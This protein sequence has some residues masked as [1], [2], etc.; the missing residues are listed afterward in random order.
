MRHFVGI[1]G[2]ALVACNGAPKDLGPPPTLTVTSPV[3]SLVQGQAGNINVT[4][5]ATPGDPS[6]TI[7]SVLVNG[8]SATV[9]TDGS[10][11]ATVQV[12][13]GATLIHTIATDSAGGTANDT[14]SVEAGQIMPPGANID[15]A[16]TASVSANAFANISA[17]ATTII[18]QTDFS[19]LIAPLQPMQEAGSSPGTGCLYDQLFVQDVKFTG[20]NL[21]LVPVQGGIQFS[22]ELDGLDVPGNVMF[23]VACISGSDTLEV[24]ADKVVVTGTLLVTPNGMNGF[25]TTLDSPNVALTNFQLNAGGL[26]GEIL[27]L[28]D[29]NSAISSIISSAAQQFMGP[30]VNQALASLAGQ[31]QVNALGQT[32]D[33]AVAPSA[34]TF[35]TTGGTISLDTQ[36]LIQAAANSPGYVGI[37]TGTPTYDPGQGLELGMSAN[38][39]N[40]LLSQATALGQLSMSMSVAGGSFDTLQMAPTSAP[41]IS[42]DP[43]SGQLELFLPDFKLTFLSGGSGGKPVGD[44]SMNAEVTL[45]ISPV[46]NGAAVAVALATPTVDVDV[47]NDIPNATYLDAGALSNAVKLSLNAQISQISGLLGAIPLPTIAGVTVR[48]VSVDGSEGYLLAKATIQ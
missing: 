28:I 20:D 30:M 15:S 25:T 17:L 6:D 24:T 10:F 23:A 33:L 45:A 18:G 36:L 5:T 39:L 35:D 16:L 40:D 22:A 47:L 3:R 27:D 29:I 41:M 31:H 8:V 7:Q 4:G 21:S 1:C 11:T 26:P 32:I 38:L 34:V 44:A 13:A 46:A 14:R 43:S 9:G 37:E 19:T 42:T 48:D 12:E 2:L